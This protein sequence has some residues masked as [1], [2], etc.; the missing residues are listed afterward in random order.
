MNDGRYPLLFSISSPKDLRAM[1]VEAMPALCE[2]I[3]S[4]L[5]EVVPRTG[6]HL[7]SNLGIVELTVALHRVFDTP[8]DR[9]IFDVGHQSYVHKLLTGRRAAFDSLRRPG[10]LSGFTRRAESELVVSFQPHK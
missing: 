9:I 7:A 1:P 6:G 2:E 5:L 4:Y 3:R 10:G 8:N